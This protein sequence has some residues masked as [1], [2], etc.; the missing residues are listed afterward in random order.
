MNTKNDPV[1]DTFENRLQKAIIAHLKLLP[2]WRNVNNVK[3][4]VHLQCLA[5]AIKMPD[6]EK[7]F[8]SVIE[9][10]TAN[11]QLIRN[12]VKDDLL[13]QLSDEFMRPNVP[14][15]DVT[16]LCGSIV[17]YLTTH[18][19]WISI[20]AVEQ[21]MR[22]TH[23]ATM[24]AISGDNWFRTAINIL[25]DA[26]KIVCNL[27]DGVITLVADDRRASY[28]SQIL[29]ALHMDDEYH[30]SSSVI[31][32]IG[33]AQGA[34]LSDEESGYIFT[35]LHVLASQK[36]IDVLR[37]PYGSLYRTRNH[38][39]APAPQSYP[40]APEA[41]VIKIDLPKDG[42]RHRIQIGDIILD[43]GTNS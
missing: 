29:K 4:D 17:G 33:I 41:T 23:P 12:R 20:G 7:A 10:M 32:Q 37:M 31:K 5:D 38:K 35:E 25:T 36:I 27:E 42:G 30:S 19:G 39:P 21:Q 8:D 18:L 28:T 14:D 1:M 2:G 24:N 9:Y 43:I 40:M 26:G 3:M 13:I 22:Q 15:E 11:S 16:A 34:D 6:Y